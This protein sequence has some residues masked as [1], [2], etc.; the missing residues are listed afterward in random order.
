MKNYLADRMGWLIASKD[1]YGDVV[2][3]APGTL[4]T[5]DPEVAHEVL[6]T[7]NDT[8]LLETGQL[9]GRRSRASAVGR[10]D[11]W[12]AVRRNIWHGFAEQLA[13]SHLSRLSADASTLLDTHAT[14]GADLVDTCRQVSGRL[15]VD[16]CLGGDGA[17]PDLR[18]E[19]AIRANALFTTALRTLQSGEPRRRWLRRPGAAAAAAADTDLRS[20]LADCVTRRR[21]EGYGGG[22]RDLLD[23]LLAGTKTGGAD[24]AMIVSVLRMAMFASHGVPGAALSW[25]VLRLADDPDTAERVRREADRVLHPGAA[26]TDGLTLT[27]AVVREVLRLH[28]PQWLLTRTAL[29]ATALDGYSVRAG[30]EVLICPYVMHRDSRFWSE[31]ERFDPERWLSPELPH[32]RHAY[33]PFGAGPRICP[34]SALALRQLGVLTAVLAR[35]F[36]LRLPGLADV[37]MTCNGLLLPAGVRGGWARGRAVRPARIAR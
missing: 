33:L 25:I 29:R 26:A 37:D 7:T 6:A 28:P 23:A 9:A 14:P 31:P 22:P 36:E 16:F 18:S 30:H 4:V 19:A 12:M 15:I 13:T 17:G 2:R 34:G 35:D 3:L 24:D 27:T 8:Y 5:H 32:A 1:R 11:S 10:L 21:A 20:L